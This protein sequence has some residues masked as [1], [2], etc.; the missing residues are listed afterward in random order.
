MP[1]RG[2]Y[3]GLDP[4]EKPGPTLGDKI[5]EEVRSALRLLFKNVAQQPIPL[6]FA[7]QFTAYVTD[8]PGVAIPVALCPTNVQVSD[9]PIQ[10]LQQQE[11]T[12]NQS[13]L[14][15]E[16]HLAA[17]APCQM[18]PVLCKAPII[19]RTNLALS[20]VSFDNVRFTEGH[21]APLEPL[22]TEIWQKPVEGVPQPAVK[23][24]MAGPFKTQSMSLQERLPKTTARENPKFFALPIRKTPIPPHR[25][26]SEAREVFRRHLA[27]KIGT[28]PSNIQLKVVFE[29]MNVAL[30]ATI[31]Q[32]ESGQLLC[33]P[34]NELIGKNVR[35]KTGQTLAAKL[36]EKTPNTYLVVGIRLDTREDIR[37]MVPVDKIS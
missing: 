10:A 34:K 21:T 20:T 18:A 5:Q 33:T 9:D 26:S 23:Q 2:H 17:E 13:A 22:Q 31:Q 25:F 15:T 36:S 37:A 6:D 16:A 35:G 4:E 7:P 28:A 11:I 32:D 8:I 29:R 12:I 14:I 1:G 30:Y 27:E 24:A 19:E 3:G